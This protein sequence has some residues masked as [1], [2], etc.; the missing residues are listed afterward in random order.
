MKKSLV[1]I[2]LIAGLTGLTGCANN[3]DNN[4]NNIRT[5]DVRD[6]VR[7]DMDLRN[8]NRLT[9]SARA[10]RNVEGLAEV[11][12]AHVIMR[13][14]NAYVAVRLNNRAGTPGTS[15]TGNNNTGTNGN[16]TANRRTPGNTTINGTPGT[17]GIT[18]IGGTTAGMNG[19]G[20]TGVTGNRGGDNT[21]NR[22]I[23]GN[24]G[25]TGNT[26]GPGTGTAGTNNIYGGAG[27]NGTAGI[28][29]ISNNNGTSGTPGTY[30]KAGTSGMTGTRGNNHGGYSRVDTAFEQRVAD[31]VRKADRNVHRVYV[32]TDANFFTQMNTYSNDIRNGRNRDGILRNFTN[33]VRGMFPNN[34]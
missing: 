33:S 20:T 31:Q 21:D 17:T 26:P 30:S 2:L 25:T 28:G 14:N 3:A 13:G 24:T 27:H 12:R 18:G 32:S 8:T 34:R 1:P 16:Y 9:V 22:I 6:N 11:D 15:I 5:T 19:V 4:R 10:A 29:N 7:N 23:T